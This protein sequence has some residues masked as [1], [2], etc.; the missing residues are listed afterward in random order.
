MILVI[1]DGINICTFSPR[2]FH[3]PGPAGPRTGSRPF[4][5]TSRRCSR[6]R[7]R[8]STW[9][10]SSVPP[11]SA[12]PSPSSPSLVAVPRFSPGSP[13]SPPPS[14]RA[15]SPSS[16]APLPAFQGGG[17]RAVLRTPP[18]ACRTHRS[19]S[20][21]PRWPC[22]PPSGREPPRPS[23]SPAVRRFPLALSPYGSLPA[24]DT[25]PPAGSS[26]VS[27]P[28]SSR[29]APSR[30]G[31]RTPRVSRTLCVWNGLDGHVPAR[32]RSSAAASC[33]RGC[34]SPVVSPVGA[35]VAFVRSA[36]SAPGLFPCP[37]VVSPRPRHRHPGLA[38][39]PERLQ[40]LRAT[41]PCTRCPVSGP[42]RPPGSVSPAVETSGSLRGGA[43]AHSPLCG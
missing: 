39:L 7:C 23:P 3:R 43:L 28:V 26:G 27:R 32:P 8:Q 40:R 35:R 38:A 36:R 10:S 18:A 16:S 41:Q 19:T 42:A 13:P 21:R 37:P 22:C 2:E 14:R 15:S 9:P 25:G 29:R 24:D 17:C 4:S 6:A 5:H 33:G 30:P 11:L 1:A 12:L 20:A 34:S 31:R